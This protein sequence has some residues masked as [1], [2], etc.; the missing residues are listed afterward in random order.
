MVN[1]KGYYDMYILC[2]SLIKDDE[3]LPS[4]DFQSLERY[5][6]QREWMPI[7]LKDEIADKKKDITQ[8][9]RPH[10]SI[11]LRDKNKVSFDIFFNGT[12]SVKN[13]MNILEKESMQEKKGFIES[14][15]SLDER[16][17]YILF[18]CEK[19]FSAAPEWETELED[20]CKNL[21][22]KKIEQLLKKIKELLE[23]RESRQSIIKKSHI[24]TVAMSVAWVS[25][26]RTDH[27]LIKEVLQKV[28][29]IF[30]ICQKIKTYSEIKK[31]RKEEEK[32]IDIRR[33]PNCDCYLE[34]DTGRSYCPSCIT[35]IFK[36]K[37]EKKEY[38]LL[39]SQNK[40]LD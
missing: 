12:Q 6:S 38:D 8:S 40:I 16:F 25:V 27:E 4:L 22:D 20:K 34:Y 37:I 36:E 14:L 2:R 19:F 15:K 28:I 7:P 24:A 11:S 3:V 9:I 10:I 35:P 33:C 1:Y 31:I 23:K 13:F 32:L 30:K 18:Y 39:K 21:D 17:Y 26:D 5:V 29:D